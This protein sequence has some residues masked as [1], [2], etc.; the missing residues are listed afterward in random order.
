MTACRALSQESASTGRTRQW[1]GPRA[2]CPRAQGPRLR[3]GVSVSTGQ[4]HANSRNL[5]ASPRLISAEGRAAHQRC[6]GFASK[7]HLRPSVS[8]PTSAL[9][10]R[11]GRGGRGT[12]G[13]R[14]DTGHSPLHFHR[15]S[16]QEP[17]L[18][19][20]TPD[21]RRSN[22]AP[23][24]SRGCGWS[25]RAPA[26]ALPAAP[27]ACGMILQLW[28]TSATWSTVLPA[29]TPRKPYVPRIRR[30][31]GRGFSKKY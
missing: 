9:S 18:Q 8:R 25:L 14:H 4:P 30:S 2:G 5:K 13:T 6:P 11:D 17:V 16:S 12:P 3:Y 21:A 23:S 20:Q 1:P 7:P 19:P 28:S 22:S 26:R 10:G 29:L 15:Q 31:R 24:K 27:A